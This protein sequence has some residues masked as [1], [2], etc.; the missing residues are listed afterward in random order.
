[1]ATQ[2][3]TVTV[4]IPSFND[5]AALQ[6]LLPRL[7]R[8]FAGTPWRASVL[9][10]D[11]ASTQPL[12]PHW[13][14]VSFECIESVSVL[15]LRSNLGHQRAIA[16]GLFHAHERSQCSAVVVM[17]GDGEDRPEDVPVLLAEFRQAGCQETI[18][19]AR[20]KR[21]ENLPFQFFYRTFRL[22][23]WLLTG[24]EVRVGNFSVIPRS[25]ISRLLTVPDVWNHY[26]AAVYR[27]RV[28]RRLVPLARG[29]RLA[30]ES[31]MNFVSL[32][33][34]GLSAISVFSD[35]VSA[36]LLAFSSLL[37]LAGAISVFR[38]GFTP[39]A[40]VLLAL[41]AQSLTVAT[42]FALTIVSRRSATNFL[43]LRDARYFIQS[44]TEF[45]SGASLHRLAEALEAA[46]AGQD[47]ARR[48]EH[49][50]APSQ[51]TEQLAQERRSH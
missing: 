20:T 29:W 36:R 13:P 4:L 43:L 11:D 31:R 27:A 46:S 30:G 10:V 1:M 37:A 50:E 48:E 25:I 41:A 3:L 18:F 33:V 49:G 24:V 8:A 9:V 19:A 32:L 16:L 12:P 14:A 45:A 17:D 2:A 26:A 28:P 5:W 40:W 7:D 22:L 35:Q 42:L 39:G 15:H 23:H 38:T 6:L 51:S 47:Q 44:E 34:H 21:M